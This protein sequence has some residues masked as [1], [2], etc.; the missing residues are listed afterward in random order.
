MN[1]PSPL[2]VAMDYPSAEAALTLVEQLDPQRCRLK[3]GKELFTRAGP[4]LIETLQ[5]RGF[6][7]F[8][9][10]KYHDIPNTVAK[11]V[12]AAADLGVW[13]VN[14]HAS[15][16]RAMMSAAVNALAPLRHRPH[17]IA[18]T[19]LT[20]LRP[21]ELLELGITV[22][23]EEQVSRLAQLAAESGVDG[24]VC[25]AQE[26]SR[27]RTERGGA[28]LLV[29]PG[30]RPNWAAE[31]DQARI[32]T[33]SE[34]IRLGS[35]YLVIGRPITAAADPLAA[36]TRIEAELQSLSTATTP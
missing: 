33:P 34:A 16:G 4:P 27:L 32:T 12:L 3:V 22:T 30:I 19:V 2:I 5:R 26:V 13:M 31:D 9:D 21:S 28:F 29:T 7:I 8:L 11:A 15:G 36:L 10:L 1:N 25:S 23:P 24:V 6:E 14:L 18:V 35:D 20:S 17:L